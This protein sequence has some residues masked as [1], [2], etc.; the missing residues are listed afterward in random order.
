MS[1]TTTPVTFSDLYTDLINKVREN[2]GLST[3]TT[4]AKRAVNSA[5]TDLHIMGAEKFPW[6]ERRSTLT[7]HPS[8][9]TGTV[10]V[11]VGSSTVTGTSTLWTTTNS[12]NQQNVRVGGKITFAGRF[13]VYDV[14]AVSGAGSLTISPAFIGT[15][16]TDSTYV[17]FEDE[18]A[19]A[20]DFARPIDLRTFDTEGRIKLIG[21]QDFRRLYPRNRIPQTILRHA[22]LLDL[23][24]SGSTTAVRKVQFAPPPSV[25]AVVPYTYVTQYLVVSSAGAE[26]TSLSADSDEPTMPVRYRPVLVYGALVHWYRDRKD[27]PRSQEAKSEYEQLKERIFGDMEIGAQRPRVTVNTGQKS[28]AR[29]PWAS[30]HRGR[31]D[32]NGEFDRFD[33]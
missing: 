9:S 29:R 30:G 1:S 25:V 12:Y 20:T 26:Q 33:R 22:T 31:F 3:T 27:D 18:Y 11:T 21:R 19:L 17:Y 2:S 32:V 10:A 23:P 5:L 4:L 6:S 15:T 24:F 13:E 28:R 14:T 7:L 16:D 8:Y